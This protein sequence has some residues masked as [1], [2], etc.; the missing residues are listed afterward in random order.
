SLKIDSTGNLQWQ[1]IF[2]STFF[3]GYN[4]SEICANGGYILAGFVSHTDPG[5]Q[6]L[7]LTRIDNQGNIIWE[8]EYDPFMGS[9]F[10][11]RIEKI[12]NGYLIFGQTND[13]L[14]GYGVPFIV[15]MD[16][17]GTIY[18][19]KMQAANVDG[20]FRDYKS[21]NSN[22]YVYTQFYDSTYYILNSRVTI[23]DSNGSILKERIFTTPNSQGYV[24]LESILPLPNGDILFAG[25]AELKLYP[26]YPNPF[27]PETII[28]F[29]IPVRDFVE[30][31]LYDIT[32]KLVSTLF[33]GEKSQGSYEYKLNANHYNLSTG[34]YFVLIR[35]KSGLILSQK[36]ILLK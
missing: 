7:L 18:F 6:Y 9:H 34:V 21:I 8:R 17:A 29:D 33:E 28:R 32:G 20:G 19:K 15:R 30:I 1:K 13:T 25:F 24:W 4:S 22:R 14:T 35:T 23:V 26:A 12:N 16:T 2:P 36:I 3:K 5:P 11:K 31:K 10:T 27:N